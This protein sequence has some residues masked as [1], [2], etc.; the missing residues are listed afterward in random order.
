VREQITRDD[1]RRA[2]QNTS[3]IVSL[4]GSPYSNGNRES[5]RGKGDVDKAEEL[6]HRERYPQ[7]LIEEYTLPTEHR[8]SLRDMPGRAFSLWATSSRR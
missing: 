1:V 7:S 4:L 3:H 2:A 5:R 8:C 6:V